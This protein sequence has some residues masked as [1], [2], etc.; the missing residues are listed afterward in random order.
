MYNIHM[1]HLEQS[2]VE[3]NDELKYNEWTEEEKKKKKHE[4]NEW[5]TEK[6]SKKSQL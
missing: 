1:N 2:T 3:L 6:N 5:E 4:E